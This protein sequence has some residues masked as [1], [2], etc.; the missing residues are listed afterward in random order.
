MFVLN[1]FEH[2][3]KK[4][5]EQCKTDK[6]LFKIS[7]QRINLNNISGPDYI[8][9]TFVCIR[10]SLVRYLSN[11]DFPLSLPL[12][13]WADT[14]TDQP[15]LPVKS[16]LGSIMVVPDSIRDKVGPLPDVSSMNKGKQTDFLLLYLY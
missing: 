8:V 10:V 12:L 4:G 14:E 11:S 1:I 2:L 13:A 7:F 6:N 16:S 5:N 9:N 3:N 15:V